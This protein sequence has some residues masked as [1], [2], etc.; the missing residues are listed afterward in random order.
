LDT[1]RYACHGPMAMKSLNPRAIQALSIFSG[2]NDRQV[3]RLLEAA[4]VKQYAVDEVLFRTGEK[5]ASLHV[6]L[7]GMV[8]LY[9]GEPP[10]EC[11]LLLMSKGD[12][13]M[14]AATLFDEPYI[15]SARTLTS[16]RIL[17]IPAEA[18]RHEFQRSHRMAVNVGRVLAGHFR[19]AA[20]HAI[21]L[22]SCSA[23]ER[24]GRFLLRLVQETQG[25]DT[26]SLPAPKGKLAARVGM[27]RETFSRALQTLA[28]N[29]LVVRGSRVIVRDR[30]RIETFCGTGGPFPANETAL[31]VHAL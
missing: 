5:S 10:R 1:K 28:D 8:E 2:L 20:R 19:M 3:G 18:T 24:L 27:T 29:G 16:S 9:A 4:S 23:P 22:R 21:E 7:A 25:G 30:A 13:F 12:L 31:D 26:A 17:L 15:N 6:L 14:P 11:G